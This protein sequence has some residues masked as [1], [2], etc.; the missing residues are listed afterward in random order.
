MKSRTQEL[1]ASVHQLTEMQNQLVESKKLESMAALVA[2]VAHEINTPIGIGITA[3]SCLEELNET[4]SQQAKDKAI[5]RKV[6]NQYLEESQQCIN[7]VKSNLDKSC[8]L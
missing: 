2:G 5:S 3:S 1:E 8:V 6:L 7:L 4:F